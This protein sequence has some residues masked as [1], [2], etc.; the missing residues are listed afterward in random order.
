MSW[1]PVSRQSA[2]DIASH[3]ARLGLS[4]CIP[5]YIGSTAPTTHILNNRSL[6]R[7]GRESPAK[8]GGD[9]AAALLALGP[10]KRLNFSGA[11]KCPFKAYSRLRR[12]MLCFI[13][14]TSWCGRPEDKE[15]KDAIRCA[16]CRFN[17]YPEVASV[18]CAPLFAS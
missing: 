16:G 5:S 11:S 14:P 9:K 7:L 3:S 17:L 12:R 6:V 2:L 13:R 15:L 8:R 1:E 10:R 4:P 18:T